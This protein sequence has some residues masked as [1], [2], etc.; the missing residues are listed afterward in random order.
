MKNLLK[1][2]LLILVYFYFISCSQNAEIATVSM[3]IQGTPVINQPDTV[4]VNPRN[5]TK[6]NQELIDHIEHIYAL[7]LSNKELIAEVSKIKFSETHIYIL[8]EIRQTLFVFT[9]DGS[10]VKVLNDSG[11][12]PGEF[13]KLTDFTFD[14]QTNQLIVLD[15]NNRKL[16]FYDSLGRFKEENRFSFHARNL[17]KSEETIVLYNDFNERLSD[18]NFNIFTSD[19]T[20]TINKHFFP[21][22]RKR[23]KTNRVKKTYLTRDKDMINYIGHYDRNWYKFKG[24]SAWLAYN[25]DFG[26]F[27][28]PPDIIDNQLD[29]FAGY[30]HGISYFHETN[31]HLVFT[32]R[33]INKF[34]TVYFNKESGNLLHGLTSIPHM[35]YIGLAYNVIGTKD[36]YFVQT[37]NPQQFLHLLDKY[38]DRFGDPTE[39]REN[40]KEFYETMSNTNENDN[41]IIIFFKLKP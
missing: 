37:I 8:D 1:L 5:Q 11:N 35:A 33:Y 19:T 13:G 24:D 20:G 30:A 21:F 26:D 7:K 16:L 32:Y 27:N 23:T 40:H 2:K 15:N 14:H 41:P 29:A 9:N 31:N 17:D 25:I 4:K 18:F 22:D 10:L 34:K 6:G 3:G 12:G 39:L 38:G 36:D 28:A